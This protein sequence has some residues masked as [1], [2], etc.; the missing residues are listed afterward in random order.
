[1]LSQLN[2]RNYV[3]IDSLEIQFPEGLVIITGQTGAGKSILLGALSLVL[4]SKADASVIGESADNCVVEAEFQLDPEDALARNIIEEN[5]LDWN[6]GSLLVRRV[7]ARTGR[8]RAFLNDEPVTLPVLAQLAPRLVDIHS[9][10]QTMLLSDHRFQLGLLDRYAGN[11]EL[12]KS[13]K[14]V[15]DALSDLRRELADLDGRIASIERDREYNEAQWKQLDAAALVDGELEEL[16][17]EQ[18]TLAN[19]EEIKELLCECGNLAENHSDELD[20][21][22]VQSIREMERLLAKL[23]RFI[24]SA[25]SL[26]SRL[27]S[28]RL[29]LDDVVGEITDLNEKMDVSPERLEFVEDRISLY[30]TLLKKH[31]AANVAELIALRDRLSENLADSS[32]LQY[33]REELLKQIAKAGKDLDSV[34]EKLHK[35]RLKASEPFAKSIADSLHYLELPL[36]VF[37]VSIQDA[38][39]GPDGSDSVVFLFSSTGR[40][41]VDV[42]KCASGGEMSRIML[43]LKDMMARYASMPAMVF[44]EIDTGVSGSV[45]DKM[46]SMICKMGSY[47][48]VFAITHL[49]QVAAKGDAH[50]LVSKSLS[51]DKASSTI[52]RLDNEQRIL[53]IAR[54]LSG[55]SLTEAAIANAKSLLAVK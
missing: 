32:V 48:Q 6:G 1:M 16:E 44:D 11:R 34:C 17:A 25:E 2:V 37:Q 52:T 54:M 23:S 14:G 5:D 35:S 4:G 12:L 18:K 27:E 10:H 50:Y 7:V 47:M 39:Q 43:C 15:W 3:L 8:S 33:R 9:Q 51:T 49:P 20:F 26:S 29:E 21:S 28:C 36:A 38:P 31:G 55:S 42:A 30:F 24:P 19:A 22:M 41:A 53:E 40:N 46:G 13:C 45:A